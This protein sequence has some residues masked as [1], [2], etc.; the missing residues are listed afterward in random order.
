MTLL[1]VALV[2]GIAMLIWD[3]IEVG[4]NDA[5]NVVNAVFGSRIL[6][7]KNAVWLAGIAVILGATFSSPVMETA[8]KGIFDPTMLTLESALCVYLS[9]YIVDTILLYS[10]SSFGL[11]IST[12][13]SLV[14]ELIG[15]SI[16][17]FMGFGIV[18]WGKVG[19][20]ILAII[21]SIL[22]SG[23]F[24]FIIQRMFRGA[25]G[26][27]W[28][29]SQT[30]LLHGPWISG[31]I[32]T[33]LSWFLIMKGMPN[34][35]FIKSLQTSLFGAFGISG[36]LILIWAVYTLIIHL[37][38][39][40]FHKKFPANLFKM[41]ALIGMLCMGFA[42]GQNDLANC[43]SPGL[44]IVWLYQHADKGI[45][46]ANEIPIPIYF[47]FGCGALIFLGMMSKR[48]H[49]VTR[50]ECNTGSQYDE[51]SLYAPK[52]CINIAKIFKKKNIQ[53]NFSPPSEKNDDG[54]KMHYDP[55]RASVIMAVSAGV[56]AFASSYG[57]PV[58]TTYVVFAAVIGTG[59]GDRIFSHGDSSLKLGRSIWV[60]FCWFFSC[61]LAMLF[62]MIVGFIIINFS[63]YGILITLFANLSIRKYIKNRSDKHELTYHKSLE[64]ES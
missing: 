62:S 48:A 60:V 6:T 9:V 12:T 47:L 5:T 41:T 37:I 11:P 59:W 15:A 34:I 56:I 8:R 42:F 20:V 24:G 14:F 31:L 40:L 26:N 63:I 4:C 25:I 64:Q 52:W 55:L 1:T 19:K 33:W 51:V 38:L 3:C 10:L 18:Y 17:V 23:T 2:V 16:G 58:S 32:F 35:V 54:K 13:A 53:D 22:F 45:D 36:A 46:I 61:L 49:R 44:S 27:K 30:L 39:T 57:Y 7:R 43:A 21:M 50:A 28:N 29:D